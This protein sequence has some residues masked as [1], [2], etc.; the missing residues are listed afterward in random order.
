VGVGARNGPAEGGVF[1]FFFFYFLFS[2]SISYFYFFYLLFF[3][4]II[5]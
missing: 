3:D 2:I 4:Q 1:S 5:S